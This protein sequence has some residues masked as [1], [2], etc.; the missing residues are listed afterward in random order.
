MIVKRVN[1]LND[2]LKTEDGT[3]LL[4]GYKRA[5]NIV[6]IEEKKD[7]PGIEYSG[8]VDESFFEHGQEKTLHAELQTAKAAAGAA[9]KIEDFSAAMAAMAPLRG[10]VDAFFDAVIVNAD[11]PII[12]RNRLCLLNQIRKTLGQVADFSKIEG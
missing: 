1:A 3:N 10:P 6:T 5:V 2:F 8:E 4:A 7:G 11:D 9:L 12:R